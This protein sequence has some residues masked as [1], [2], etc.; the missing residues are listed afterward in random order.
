MP[1]WAIYWAQAGM[2]GVQTNDEK[3]DILLEKESWS[4]E[5]VGYGGD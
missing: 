5:K 4:Y 1:A 2:D 3:Y